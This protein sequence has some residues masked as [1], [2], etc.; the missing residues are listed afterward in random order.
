MENEQTRVFVSSASAWKVATKVRLA[1]LTWSIPGSVALI[2][3]S[4][5]DG[6]I[7]KA[8]VKRQL[9]SLTPLFSWIVSLAPARLR[10]R[11]ERSV[12]AFGQ[13]TWLWLALVTCRSSDHR[14]ISVVTADCIPLAL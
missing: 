1:K 14:A 9:G 8:E 7:R 12:R 3:D 10:C 11:V 5:R 13:W 6:I 2:V 4:S